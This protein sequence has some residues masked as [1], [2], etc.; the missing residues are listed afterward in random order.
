MAHP[1]TVAADPS[2]GG[3]ADPV[4]GRSRARWIVA[5]LAVTQTVAYG[6]LYYAFA[7]FLT[8]LATDLHTSTTAI[9]GT[10]TASV[11]TSAVLAVP[12][13][14]W[15]DRHGG[16]GLM[17]IGSLA[18]ALLLV[19][20][21][22]V[23]NLWQLYAVQIGLS[24]ASAASLYEAAFAV[25]T[26][27]QSASLRARPPRRPKPTVGHIQRRSNCA[28]SSPTAGSGCWPSASRPTPPPSP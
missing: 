28:R 17:T 16:R 15:L 24:A 21:S 27:W 14:R 20:W 1:T 5:A 10:F 12:V 22:L 11:L 3:H 4:A 2:I 9:T 7:V 6:T 26:H 25:I 18:G 13:G 23:D 19:A 8:P